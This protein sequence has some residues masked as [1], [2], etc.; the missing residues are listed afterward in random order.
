[1]AISEPV[2]IEWGLRPS[3]GTEG[4][5]Q[6]SDTCGHCMADHDWHRYYDQGERGEDQPDESCP[7]IMDA[8]SGEHSY[9]NEDGPPEWG[10]GSDGR[11][12]CKEYKPCP[13]KAP[14]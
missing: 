5:M 8:L 1:M 2:Q 10:Y 11:W 7:I 12:Y 9:P 6:E 3:N 4:S 14:R 13:C